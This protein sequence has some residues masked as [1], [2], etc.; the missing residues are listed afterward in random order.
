MWR[1]IRET[2]GALFEVRRDDVTVDTATTY[3]AALGK[4]GSLVSSALGALAAAG[5][6]PETGDGLLPER[7]VNVEGIAMSENTGDGR[8]FT[9]VKWTSRDPN[10]STLPLML[11]VSNM[12]GH[13]GAEWVGYF[14][15]FKVAD[16]TPQASG[17]FYDN[18]GG[19]R[20]RDMMLSRPVGISVDPGAVDAEFTCTESDDWGFCIDGQTTFTAYEVI[21]ATITPFPAFARAAIQLEG[22][23]SATAS[24]VDRIDGRPVA[25]GTS[26][27]AEGT[28]NPLLDAV[29]AGAI[30]IPDVLP[31]DGFRMAEPEDGDPLLVRQPPQFEG[32]EVEHWAVPLTVTDDGRVF[33][34][35]AREGQC[36][37]GIKG[38]CVTAPVSMAGFAFFHLGVSRTDEGDLATG[39]L[40][41]GCDHYPTNGRYPGAARAHYDNTGLQWADVRAVNGRHGTWVCGWLRP[42]VTANQLRVI[43]ASTLSGDWED[44]G[45]NLEM[46]AAQ[47]VSVPGFPVLREWMAASGLWLPEIAGPKVKTVEGR[48]VSLSAA[49][50][51]RRVCSDCE[52][53][54][55]ARAGQGSSQILAR[56]LTEMAGKLERIDQR[57]TRIDQ[58]TAPL[59]STAAER[60][61]S[62]IS[63]TID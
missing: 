39:V 58:R 62:R 34:H 49:G 45:G 28:R 3:E 19:V 23:V 2:T 63:S 15:S 22:A 25:V 35:A 8:D 33:G 12:G 24:G 26:F 29:T 37:V 14:E 1:I 21:G 55:L 43:R 52:A 31:A 16:G 7:W 17:R 48:V 53:R 27:A 30:E 13:Y 10:V 56:I 42:D 38:E 20:A 51:V 6:G 4:L 11:S 44:R 59:R 40:I 32:D 46:I 60:L 18:E 9:G 61:R 50:M 41:A 36:H 54:R 5:V 47:C 57:V